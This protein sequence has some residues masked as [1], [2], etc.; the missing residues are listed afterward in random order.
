MAAPVWITPPGELGTIVEGEFYQVKLGASNTVQY[1]FHS[2]RLPDGIV[3]RSNGTVE[4]YPSNK[5]YIQGVPVEVAVDTFNQFS[6]RATSQDGQ[7]ADRIFSLTVTGPDTPVI[8]TLP[9]SQLGAFFDGDTVN[10]Q[11]TATDEDPGQ[12]LTWSIVGGDFPAGLNLSSTGAITGYISPLPSQDGTPGYDVE[13]FDIGNFDFSTISVTKLYTFKAQVSD[14]TRTAEKEYSMLVVS[15]NQL[16][17]DTELLT[18]DSFAPTATAGTANTLFTADGTPKRAP[19]M[20]TP[21]GDLGTFKHDNWFNYKFDGIDLDGDA[22]VYEITSDVAEGFDADGSGFDVKTFDVGDYELPPGLILDVNTGWFTGELPGLGVTT[23]EYNWAVRVKKKDDP[24]FVSDWVYFTMT[25]EGDVDKSITWPDADIGILET[26][27][28]S[29]LD[30]IAQIGSGASVQYELKTDYPQSLPQ[31]LQL[32]QNG[33]LIGRVSFETFMLDTGL[34][35]FD[36]EHLFY[37]ET[38]WH[39]KYTFTVRAFSNDGT[40]DTFKTFTLTIKPSSRIPYESLYVKALP[41]QTQREIYNDLVNNADDIN[42]A[43]VYRPSDYYFGVQ[44]DIRMLIATGLNPSLETD[45]VEATS[46]NHFNNILRF[47]NLKTAQA[48]NPDGTVRYEVVYIELTDKGVGIDPVSKRPA[49]VGQSIDLRSSNDW[50]NRLTVDAGEDYYITV[51]SGNYRA[52]QHNDYIAYPNAIE[53]MRTRLKT[54]IGEAILE[55]LV[56]PEWMQS[57]QEDQSI[58]GWTLAAPLVYCKPGKSKKIKYL[59]EQRTAIDLKLISFEVDRYILDNNLSKYY[60][61]E[62]GKYTVTQETTFDLYTLSISELDKSQQISATVDYAVDGIAFDAI[63]NKVASDIVKLEYID[64]VTDI[65]QFTGDGIDVVWLQQT[66]LT[67]STAT[68]QTNDGWNLESANFGAVYDADGTPFS[69]T[70]KINGYVEKYF[71]GSASVNQ[72]GGVWN[73][74]S[75]SGRLV[76]TFKQEIDLGATVRVTYL[77]GDYFYE[78]R[79]SGGRTAPNYLRVDVSASTIGE[80]FF[81]GGGTEFFANVDKY[82]Y[83]DDED[84]YIKFPQVGVF[85]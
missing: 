38:T 15:R 4:G 65:S 19:F 63:N 14:G 7:V 77:N 57:K 5:D 11:L 69:E 85:K 37:D 74:K 16:T 82:E 68:T 31:G 56:L 61:K 9:Q 55:R 13:A 70:T 18:A 60:N 64:G 78:N 36:I 46:Q 58:L 43:D 17:A 40:I 41:N 42:P 27:Q 75:V 62:T 73:I 49:P 66:G 25:I 59:L 76:C 84:K 33:L 34:T 2:G 52:T 32:N 8:D 79:P 1:K 39:R 81:D 80:T 53:N 29:E 51:D 6:V 10:F 28:V 48:L 22:I 24:L 3:I 44:R 21:A 72:R 35:T 12:T 26:G 20:L 30:I 45:Y 83:Q 50:T 47:G 23:T 71:A 54:A 67:G